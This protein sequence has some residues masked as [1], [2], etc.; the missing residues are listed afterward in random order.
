VRRIAALPT[1]EERRNA[2]QTATGMLQTHSGHGGNNDNNSSRS[3]GG[4][5]A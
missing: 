5:G 4:H 1:M 3:N 2:L